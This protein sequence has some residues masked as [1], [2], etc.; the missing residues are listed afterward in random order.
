MVFTGKGT[1][2]RQISSAEEMVKLITAN[3]NLI[4]FVPAGSA[5]AAKVAGKF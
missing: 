1:P 5:G 3:P 4:G 2:P